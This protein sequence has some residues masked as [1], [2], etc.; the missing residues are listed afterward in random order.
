MEIITGVPPAE[1]GDKDS[2]VVR[3]VTKSGLDQPKPTGSVGGRLRLVQQPDRRRRRSA[4]ATHTVGNF[5]SLSGLRTDRFLDPPEFEALHERGQ[6][7][8]VLRPRRLPSERRRRHVAPERP[9][10]PIV[11]RRAQHLRPGGRR[12]GPASEDHDLQRRARLYARAQLEA[13]LL[14]ANVFVRRDTVDYTPSADPFADQPGTVVAE[15]RADGTSA[16]KS[17]SSYVQRRPQRE[18][19][20]RGQ[21]D[22]ARP[23]HFSLGLTDPTVNSPCLDGDGAPSDDAHSLR[24]DAQCAAAGLTANP[25]FVPG[26]VAFDLSRGGGLFQFN[27]GATD[28]GSRRST[29]RTRSRRATRPSSWACAA[30]ATTA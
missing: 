21:R 26:L 14:A 24:S 7:P 10:R 23:K 20:R 6:Q 16:P 30:T 15:P 18:V 25:D 1:F 4:P 8:V 2:L 29:C 3:I 27:G 22:E 19:R 11:V 28:Q 9:R 13:L 12:P 17:T 5:L